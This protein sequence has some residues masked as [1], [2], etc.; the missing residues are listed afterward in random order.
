VT[1]KKKSNM[2]ARN[3]SKSPA[4]PSNLAP[5]K[6][7]LINPETGK[8]IGR[9]G[10]KT[11]EELCEKE[12]RGGLRAKDCKGTKAEKARQAKKSKQ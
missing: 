8:K 2:P 4:R 5:G 7:T 12:N 1:T 11:R 3:R 6:H 10:S 9:K